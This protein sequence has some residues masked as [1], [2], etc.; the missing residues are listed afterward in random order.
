MLGALQGRCARE[1]QKA[2]KVSMRGHNKSEC[3]QVVNI[4]TVQNTLH[5]LN[6]SSWSYYN[7]IGDVTRSIFSRMHTQWHGK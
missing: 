4:K 7:R 6:G 2:P 1:E 3:P 5:L